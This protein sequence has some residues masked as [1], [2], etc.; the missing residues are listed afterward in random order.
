M[1]WSEKQALCQDLVGTHIADG[2][3]EDPSRAAGGHASPSVQELINR[4]R[5][6][7]SGETLGSFGGSDGELGRS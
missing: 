4:I 7:C 5:A 2:A 3:L 1:L 6:R